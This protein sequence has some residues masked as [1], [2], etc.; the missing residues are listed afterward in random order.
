MKARFWQFSDP[1]SVAKWQT[2]CSQPKKSHIE[3]AFSEF[4]L[5]AGVWNYLNDPGIQDKLIATHKDI[6]EWLVKFEK[7]YR[8]Q[9]QTKA[10]NLGD[11]QWRD[12]MAVYF[13]AMVRFSKDWTDMRIRN[14]REVWTERLV[15]LNMQ[16]QQALAASGTRLAAQI[17]TQRYAVL[18]NLDDINKWDTKFEL[19]TTFD[20]EIFQRE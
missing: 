16:Y 1:M 12:F 20:E 18:K 14:L 4:K 17:Q 11:I 19:R 9:Y 15:Q 13:Q 10:M 8:K 2:H 6:A 7:L 3:R 5:I